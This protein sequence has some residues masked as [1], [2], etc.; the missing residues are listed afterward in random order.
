VAS[1]FI[2]TSTAGV[3][4]D[5]ARGTREQAY[6]DE[7]ADFI[8]R[9]VDDGFILLGGPLP[10][11]GGAVLVVRAGSEAD[12]RERLATDPWYEQGI[13][14]LESI[15]RWDVFINRWPAVG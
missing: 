7:H 8:D 2:V 6:W 15:R 5:H 4:R 3:N 1:T 12:V 14:A 10:D 13:L 9:L 11:E